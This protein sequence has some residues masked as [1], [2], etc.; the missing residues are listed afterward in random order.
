MPANR[1]VPSVDNPFAAHWSPQD[2]SLYNHQDFYFAKADGMQRKYWPTLAPLFGSLK[3]EENKGRQM[4]TVIT[5]PSPIIRQVTVPS[6]LR[7]APK[8]DVINVRERTFI[9]EPFWH[10]FES[11]HMDWYPDF[12]DY[13][14][15]I[16]DIRDNILKQMRVFEDMFLRSFM[17][18]YADN[19]YI[20]GHGFVSA[21]SGPLTLG[22]TVATGTPFGADS[23]KPPGWWQVQL[24]KC[25][26]HLTFQDIFSALHGGVED[27]GM[28]PFEGEETGPNAPL[29]ERFCIVTDSGTYTQLVDDPWLKE[30]RPLNMNIVTEK[31]RGDIFGMARIKLEKYG[32]RLKC[33]DG[34][35]DF[36][37]Y[38]PPC[39]TYETNANAPDYN[40]TKPHSYYARP[41]YKIS[42]LIG[43]RFADAIKLGAPPAAWVKG[44]P[45]GFADMK[46]NGEVYTTKNFLL[47]D[48]SDNPI[49][50]SYGRKLRM[51]GTGNFG[52]R[53][54]N[55]HN[56]IPIIHLPRIGEL[57]TALAPTVGTIPVSQVTTNP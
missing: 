5:E 56:V 12:T 16:T 55:R 37:P 42:W 30:N 14:S 23:S 41:D 7:T 1:N 34:E 24:P 35:D 4:K 22:T 2:I 40:R 54:I 57:Q 36:V 45:Q 53:L 25:K 10:D 3:W 17:L 29:N 20:C 28:T 9:T 26:R 32:L 48:S 50:N 6:N 27:F 39:E 18:G 51:Q 33:I 15:H 21:A 47:Y 11:P 31:F 44:Y 19:V 43:G 52:A 49:A 8:T 46:W 13:L 38:L